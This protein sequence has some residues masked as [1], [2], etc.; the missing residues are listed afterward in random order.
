[1]KTVIFVNT[2]TNS[3]NTGNIMAKLYD[4]FAGNTIDNV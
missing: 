4:K 1:M 3:R 2:L